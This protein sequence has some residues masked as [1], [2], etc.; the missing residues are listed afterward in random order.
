MAHE[1]RD[2]A[3]N[4]KTR[5]QCNNVHIVGLPEKTEGRDPTEFIENWLL[6]VFGKDA[7]TPLFAVERAHRVPP[8]ALPDNTPRL[9]LARLLHYWDRE[10]VLCLPRERPTI[11]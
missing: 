2:K 4:I 8:R 7:F 6:E 3:D 10:K 5:L 9:V 1:N 11:K